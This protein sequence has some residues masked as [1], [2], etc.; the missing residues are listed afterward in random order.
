MQLN[1]MAVTVFVSSGLP[2]E[3]LNQLGYPTPSQCS[4]QW[5]NYYCGYTGVTIDIIV[6]IVPVVVSQDSSSYHQ[7]RIQGTA[8]ETSQRI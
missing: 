2:I 5:Y 6:L 7:G 3:C 8:S 1:V 4:S